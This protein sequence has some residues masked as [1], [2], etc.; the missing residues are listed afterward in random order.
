MLITRQNDRQAIQSTERRL[1]EERRQ[2]QSIDA[3]LN[4]ERKH[5]KQAEE[6]AARL[7]ALRLGR[8]MV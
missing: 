4:V 6:K 3:L 2:R 1:I 7:V 5:R 8:Y